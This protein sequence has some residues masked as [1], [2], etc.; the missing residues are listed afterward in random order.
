[1]SLNTGHQSNLRNYSR[2]RTVCSNDSEV[3]QKDC[4]G[5]ANS[6]DLIKLLLEMQFDAGLHYL[7]RPLYFNA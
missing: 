3:R 7:F 4:E 2:T 6:E 1:M 5:T